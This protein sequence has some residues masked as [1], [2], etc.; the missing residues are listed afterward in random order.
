MP[1]FNLAKFWQFN[2]SHSIIVFFRRAISM[3]PPGRKVPHV[4][5]ALPCTS[6]SVAVPGDTASVNDRC[7][8][9]NPPTPSTPVSPVKFRTWNS[10]PF[11]RKDVYTSLKTNSNVCHLR[12]FPVQSGSVIRSRRTIREKP[13]AR[14][15]YLWCVPNLLLNY[16]SHS[17]R[18]RLGQ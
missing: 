8:P 4:W 17:E 15:I 3:I 16:S 2:F 6:R 10:F 18:A 14:S 11:L 13:F 9:P 7:I 12:S 5:T 1:I